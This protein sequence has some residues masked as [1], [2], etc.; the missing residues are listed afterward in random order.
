MRVIEVTRATKRLKK[1]ILPFGRCRAA[2]RP[3]Y[4][5]MYQTSGTEIQNPV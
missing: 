5:N 1:T 2:I 3:V 4:C